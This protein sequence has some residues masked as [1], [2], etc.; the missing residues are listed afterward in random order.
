MSATIDIDI[1]PQPIFLH[2]IAL[3]V[4][5]KCV[6]YSLVEEMADAFDDL[7]GACVDEREKADAVA[8]SLKF[9]ELGVWLAQRK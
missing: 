2:D 6:E 4:V 8:T 1:D 7:A 5:D 3:E 9:R